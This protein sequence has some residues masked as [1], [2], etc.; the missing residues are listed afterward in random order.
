MLTPFKFM[1]F[2][3]KVLL[4]FILVLTVSVN[5]YGKQ[6]D[7]KFRKVEATGRA[8]LIE[9]NL[10]VSRKRAIEDALYIAALKGGAKVRG[11]SAIGADT[12]INE[13][14]VVSA[15]SKVIDFKL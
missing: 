10:E 6:N 1:S 11:F 8:I 7:S 12:I 2:K 5:A 9:G 13:Q 14:S 3:P 4:F 15:A